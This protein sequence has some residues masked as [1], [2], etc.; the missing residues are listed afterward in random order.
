M[1]ASFLDGRD[2]SLTGLLHLATV[3]EHFLDL[4]DAFCGSVSLCEGFG[5][6]GFC[7]FSGG[8]CY[9]HYFGILLLLMYGIIILIFDIVEHRLRI[10]T[11][12]KNSIQYNKK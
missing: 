5:F 2:F 3:L 1:L 4:S 8:F 6:A 12:K 9:A 7:G 10:K 11:K